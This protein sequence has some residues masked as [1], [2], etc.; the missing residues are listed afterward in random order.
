MKQNVPVVRGHDPS[1]RIRVAA[2]AGKMHRVPAAVAGDGPFGR[3]VD[4]GPQRVRGRRPLPMT[5]VAVHAHRGPSYG[6]QVWTTTTTSAVPPGHS[7]GR[8]W[9][10]G[11][12]LEDVRNARVPPAFLPGKRGVR[13]FSPDDVCSRKT[14]YL[15]D[16]RTRRGKRLLP[17]SKRDNTTPNTTPLCPFPRRDCRAFVHRREFTTGLG[18]RVRKYVRNRPPWRNSAAQLK[19]R[20]FLFISNVRFVNPS[21]NRA[22][23]TKNTRLMHGK[24]KNM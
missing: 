2:S 10:E 16:L 4:A 11:R 6:R 1:V 5:V 15:R 21:E 9:T 17:F 12:A 18:F 23:I 3:R 14:V 22:M 24:P 20:T 13:L 8:E 19:K 7:V